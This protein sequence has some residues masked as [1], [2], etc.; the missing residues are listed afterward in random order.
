MRPV[1]P[2]M[3]GDAGFTW[4]SEAIYPQKVVV[5]IAVSLGVEVQVGGVSA[6]AR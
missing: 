1:G 6:K 4:R 3:Y 2:V 5:K